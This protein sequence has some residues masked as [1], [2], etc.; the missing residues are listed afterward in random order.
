MK[1]VI[2]LSREKKMKKYN[3][4]RMKHEKI[5]IEMAVIGIICLIISLLPGGY[6]AC[7]GILQGIGTGLF[8]GVAILFVGGTKA[9][10]INDSKEAIN[11][12]YKYRESIK[13]IYSIKISDDNKLFTINGIEHPIA[14]I[15]YAA[16]QLKIFLEEYF[17]NEKFYRIMSGKIIE[18]QKGYQEEYY[19]RAKKLSGIFGEMMTCDEDFQIHVCKIRALI[20]EFCEDIFDSDIEDEINELISKYKKAISR[21]NHSRI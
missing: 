3:N 12:I 7:T 19:E 1:D 13:R 17:D 14:M 15:D 16:F 2:N 21:M 9:Y 10:E 18:Y 4:K 20:N 11:F 8:T 5:A 6:E